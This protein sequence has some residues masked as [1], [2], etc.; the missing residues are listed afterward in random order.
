MSGI[1]LMTDPWWG[2][3]ENIRA[4]PIG[5]DPER[6]ERLDLMLVSHNHIDH[7]SDPAIRLAKRLGSSVIGSKKAAGRAR[8]HCLKNVVSLS[9]GQSCQHSPLVI[10]A[11]PADHPF[12]S[13]AVGFVVKGEK[14]FYFSGDTRYTPALRRALTDFQPDVAMLQVAAST[15]PFIGRD[16][17]D[18]DDAA[19]LVK[20]IRPTVVVPMHFQVK[21]KVIEIERLRAWKVDAQLVIPE[22]GR[23]CEI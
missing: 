19:R 17:M 4:V 14:I 11:V 5:L 16:G 6:L 13:D 10:T 15:Y 22:P 12:A 8:K 23:P 7:W 18:L 20:D 1:S 9:P 21:G 2:Q 3:W